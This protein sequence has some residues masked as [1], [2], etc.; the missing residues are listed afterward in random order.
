M[1]NARWNALPAAVRAA[2][3]DL[4]RLGRRIQAVAL[5]R[6]ASPAPKPGIHPVL[7]LLAERAAVLAPP[8]ERPA[9]PA[10]ETLAALVRALP[11]RAEAVE[12]VWDGD[13]E[14]WFVVL[15]AVAADPRAEAELAVV[16]HG[17][18]LR[19]FGPGSPRWTEAEAARVLGRTVAQLV[20]MPFCFAAPDGPD[21]RAPRWWDRSPRMV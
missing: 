21:D 17:T 12:A 1:D 19:L 13:T 8:P 3:D 9:P 5:I 15:Y 18:D 2:A 11:F 16:R 6:D 14:G 10:P 20:G 7:D 4:L